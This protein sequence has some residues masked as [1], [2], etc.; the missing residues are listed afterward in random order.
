MD[1]DADKAGEEIGVNAFDDITDLKN[2]IVIT[3]GA[4]GDD[5]NIISTIIIETSNKV[6]IG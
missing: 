2:A 3:K 5:A 1:A 6:D 4:T